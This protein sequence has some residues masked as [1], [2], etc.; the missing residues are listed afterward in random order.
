MTED[1]L[2]PR[3]QALI[4]SIAGPDRTPDN[5]GPD[6]PLGESGYWFDSLDVLEVILA[7]EREFGIVFE[8]G[9]DLTADTLLSARRL[10]LLI[11]ARTIA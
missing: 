9:D 11:S 4:A 3:V 7:C 10:A 6:T 2:L 5:A 8:S 1:L